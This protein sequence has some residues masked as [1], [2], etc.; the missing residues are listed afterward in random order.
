MI[1][2]DYLYDFQYR[3]SSGN[4]LPLIQVQLQ[5][6]HVGGAGIDV[7]AV[8]DTG[9]GLSLFDGR[10]ATAIGLD[11]LAGAR[12]IYQPTSG[13]GLEGYLH[14]VRLS[15]EDLGNF[16][17]EIGFS[18]GPINRNLLGRDFFDRIQVGFR[19]HHAS[20]FVTPQP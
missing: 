9:A 4:R 12:K 5:T 20:F 3:P 18:N 15:H 13:P 10:F 19:E 7:D 16:D 8:L 2:V 6:G 1:T 17:M 14:R 11:L